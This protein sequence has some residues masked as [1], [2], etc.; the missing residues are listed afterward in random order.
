MHDGMMSMSARL[1]AR[2][3]DFQRLRDEGFEIDVRSGFLIV[4]CVPYITPS[5]TVARGVVVTGLALND[6][7]ERWFRDVDGLRGVA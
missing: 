2:S 4:R 3:T 5:K 6:Q 7:L 1:I